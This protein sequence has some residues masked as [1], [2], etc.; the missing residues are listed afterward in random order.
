MK[1][2]AFSKMALV[3]WNIT[4]LKYNENYINTKYDI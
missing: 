2:S 1:L 3:Y 4:I